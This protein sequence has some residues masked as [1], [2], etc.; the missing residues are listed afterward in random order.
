MEKYSILY[1]S[2]IDIDIS[3]ETASK[4]W[5]V[6]FSKIKVFSI[7]IY[8]PVRTKLDLHKHSLPSLKSYDSMP[9]RKVS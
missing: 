8:C 2:R 9:F 4:S 5:W 7:T 3:N 1:T 6:V